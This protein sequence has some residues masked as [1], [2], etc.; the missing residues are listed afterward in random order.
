MPNKDGACAQTLNA[1]SLSGQDKMSDN[2]IIL[3][4]EDP[5]FLPEIG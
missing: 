2:W 5:Q 1:Q 4:P 3:I